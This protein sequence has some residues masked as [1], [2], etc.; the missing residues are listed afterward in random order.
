VHF[1]PVVGKV[2]SAEFT[3]EFT[4]EVRRAMPEFLKA[5][6]EWKKQPSPHWRR[7]QSGIIYT[8]QMITFRIIVLVAVA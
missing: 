3:P 8:H 5:A 6:E 2:C 4:E 7:S 1:V